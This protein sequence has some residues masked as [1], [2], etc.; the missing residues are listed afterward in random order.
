MNQTTGDT[1]WKLLGITPPDGASLG[2]WQWELSWVSFVVWFLITAAGV[3]F[4]I[5]LYRRESAGVTPK[6]GTFLVT[7]SMVGLRSPF[8]F[9]WPSGNTPKASGSN[10]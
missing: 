6:L 8:L 10:P 4:A 3:A 9:R 2:A 1:L 5:R 7:L